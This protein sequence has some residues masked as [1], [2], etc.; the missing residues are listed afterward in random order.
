[1]FDCDN[2]ARGTALARR[3][4]CCE[5]A[6]D[7]RF[8]HPEEEKQLVKIGRGISESDARRFSDRALMQ[9]ASNVFSE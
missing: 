6:K 2:P 8:K 3:A 1:M 9:V 4:W 7:V 5:H